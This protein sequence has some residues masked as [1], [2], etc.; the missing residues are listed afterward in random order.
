MATN[1]LFFIPV[2]TP[3]TASAATT[4]D[5]LQHNVLSDCTMTV[6]G[7]DFCIPQKGAATKGNA[8]ASHK[9]AGKS[10]LRYEL[11]V[12]IL[13]G[14]LVWI[15]GPYPAGK[16]TDIKIFN[17]VL[18]NFLEPGE[19][20]E[21]DEGYRGHHDKTKCPGNDPHPA[22]N[23]GMQGRVRTRHETLNGRLKNW[24]ILSQVFRHHIRMHGD[25]FRACAV[26]TQLTVDRRE[27]R[28]AFRG[29]VR[30]LIAIK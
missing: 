4:T 25:V 18:R 22:E 13:A 15:Q 5:H 1:H 24:G 7:T 20:V 2:L 23:R 19:R 11:G 28:A 12:D 29:G 8:F 3:P 9:Y 6:D 30:G 16:Y 17:K 21:A 10:A 26:V 27:R 14:N